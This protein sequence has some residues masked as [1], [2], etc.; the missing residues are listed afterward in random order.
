GLGTEET[1]SKMQ[2]IDIKFFY[3]KLAVPNNCV[4]AIFGD[5]KAEEVKTAVEKLLGTWEKS[6]VPIEGAPSGKQQAGDLPKR[7][8]ETRDKKQAVLI[9]SYPGVDLYNPDH[10]A[11]ELLQ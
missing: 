6:K 10:Y 11:L 9:V 2:T 3:Q 1:V 5:V 8:S 4:I 7:V